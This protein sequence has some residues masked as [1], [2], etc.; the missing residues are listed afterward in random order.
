MADNNLTLPFPVVPH[1][2]LSVQMR[3]LFFRKEKYF[4]VFRRHK[5]FAEFLLWVTP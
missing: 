1:P 3:L 4:D 2:L 5:F